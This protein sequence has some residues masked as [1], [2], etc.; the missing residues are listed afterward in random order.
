MVLLSPSV[1]GLRKLLLVCEQY[2]NS[3]GLK[4]NCIKSEL[5]IF[6]SGNKCPEEVPPVLLN[7][8]PLKRV[9]VFKYLGHVLC[10]DMCDDE[11]IK[12]ERRAL[13]TRANMLAHRF[14]RCTVPVKITLFKAFC[15]SLYT[16]ALWASCT[17]RA[18]GDLRVQYNNAFR[19]LM[20]LPRWCSASGMFAH[21]RVD[22]F[23]A[24]LRA[25]CAASLCRLR[26]SR[27]SLLAV[28][29]DRWDSQLLIHWTRMH[30]VVATYTYN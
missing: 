3:H 27:N 30:S 9:Y 26:G 11:D 24:M 19:A 14:G 23:Q 21:A 4:Y 18:L 28:L 20:R 1:G 10:D 25:R 29:A 7:G 2:A 13:A 12:R 5:M 8:V 16:C 15:T 17:Q 6:K 22:G